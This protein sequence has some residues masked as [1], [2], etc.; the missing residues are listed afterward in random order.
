MTRNCRTY[1][2]AHD[3]DLLLFSFYSLHSQKCYIIIDI[4]NQFEMPSIDVNFTFLSRT[5]KYLKKRR[6][7]CDVNGA[8]R[9]IRC[10]VVRAFMCHIW[11][12]QNEKHFQIKKFISSQTLIRF[13]LLL[14]ISLC[15]LIYFFSFCYFV[16][17]S[18]SVGLIIII[19]FVFFLFIFIPHSIDIRCACDCILYGNIHRHHH[20][21]RNRTYE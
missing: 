11:N 1:A 9:F 20:H 19:F 12:F 8:I 18:P 5:E 17:F 3:S 14:A 13:E 10:L 6:Q 2:L 4:L 15:L 21:R 16:T 7:H